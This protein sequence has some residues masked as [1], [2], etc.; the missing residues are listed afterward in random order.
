ML[1][2]ELHRILG[3]EVNLDKSGITFHNVTEIPQELREIPEKD[4][5][6]PY[7]Y[8]GVLTGTTVVNGPA[9]INIKQKVAEKMDEIARTESSSVNYFRRVNAKIMGLLRYSF[10]T[11]EWPLTQLDAV[12][13]L[14]RKKMRDAKIYGNGMSMYRLYVDRK[15]LGHGLP[16]ARDEYGMELLRTI[17]HYAWTNDKR[18]Q[19]IIQSEQNKPHSM[20]KRMLQAWRKKITKT[21]LESIARKYEETEEPGKKEAD[22]LL[23]EVHEKIQ[24]YYINKWKEQKVSGEIRREFEKEWVD[25]E[26]TGEAWRQFNI[27]K[28]AYMAVVRMQENCTMN[29]WRKA[30]IYNNESLKFCKYCKQKIASNTHILLGCT[31]TKK[32]QIRQHDYIAEQLYRCAE[33]KYNFPETN[34]IPNHRKD[35]DRRIL[36]NAN[37]VSNAA[38]KFPKRPDVFYKDKQQIVIMDATV[39]ADRN[40]NKAYTAKINKYETLVDFFRTA[41]QIKHATIIPMVVSINGLVHK[42]STKWIKNTLK[43][44]IDWNTVLRN[45]VVRNMK[46]IMYYNGINMD[47]QIDDEGQQAQDI[48][49]T[50][51]ESID[52]ELRED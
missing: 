43:Q 47:C 52:L 37:V 18:I 15:E 40:M 24:Q 45:L 26:T 3:L 11:L 16:N 51:S 46:T 5:S 35:E 31:S 21:E 22:K 38:G 10:A 23:Q 1:I 41:T 42:E 48:T 2:K 28:E 27:K 44:R 13:K 49:T 29:G 25:R 14:I 7:K 50:Q 6:D 9:I 4:N 32:K 34:P 17:V 8:L 30:K 12:D 19:T 33:R 39:V 20:S 36:W